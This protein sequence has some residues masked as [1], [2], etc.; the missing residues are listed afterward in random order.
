MV[1]RLAQ[2]DS[3]YDVSKTERSLVVTFELVSARAS[4]GKA[5]DEILQ[6]A[7]EAADGGLISALSITDNAG[8]H[9]ALSPRALGSEIIDLG[10]DPIIHFSWSDDQEEG[11]RLEHAARL[12]SILR[13]LGY[14]GVHLSSLCRMAGWIDGSSSKRYFTSLEYWIKKWLYDCRRCGDCTLREMGFL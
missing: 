7:R 10:I 9:P 12:V 13:G 3:G 1:E 11:A 6:F 2:R 14:E 8:G 5:I 4:K